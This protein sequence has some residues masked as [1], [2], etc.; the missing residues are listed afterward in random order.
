MR[1]FGFSEN[2]PLVRSNSIPRK[3]QC[4]P[5]AIIA[6]IRIR[7]TVAGQPPPE[8]KSDSD[9]PSLSDLK[10]GIIFDM[11]GFVQQKGECRYPYQFQP[12]FKKPARFSMEIS[13]SSTQIVPSVFTV[14]DSV[15]F[16]QFPRWKKWAARP[17][18]RDAQ[19][20]KALHI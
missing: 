1:D 4:I 15:D 7:F 18:I 20:L 17:A 6:A 12:F 5:T 16:F 11:K 13:F 19:P 14:T 8:G 3:R 10:C 9:L 2:P